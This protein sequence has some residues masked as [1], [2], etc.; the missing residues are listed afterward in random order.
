MTRREHR[1]DNLTRTIWEYADKRTLELTPFSGIHYR[2]SDSGYTMLDIWPTT[3]RYYILSTDYAELG[4][5]EIERGGEKGFLPF[6]T[7]VI[8]K[9]LDAIFYGPSINGVTA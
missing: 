6:E 5:R 3:G 9:F 8:Y 1:S 4:L 7:E 2:L